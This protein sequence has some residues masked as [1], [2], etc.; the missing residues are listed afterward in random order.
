MTHSF[1]NKGKTIRDFNSWF[2]NG[3]KQSKHHYNE[4]GQKHGLCETCRE[5][6]TRKDSTV[7]ENGIIIETRQYYNNGLLRYWTKKC[8]NEIRQEAVYFA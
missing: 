6:G 8:K 5:D 1:F 2:S 7:Y 4:S 3:K